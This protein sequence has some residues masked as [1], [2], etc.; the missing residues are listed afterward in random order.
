VNIERY[1]KYSLK[2]A[3]GFIWLMT[4]IAATKEQGD[5]LTLLVNEIH[6]AHGWDCSHK[7]TGDR[8]RLLMH[9]IHD[10]IVTLTKC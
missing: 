3:L 8:L 10:T 6:L 7:R 5:R 2:E 1:K 9:E 4:G